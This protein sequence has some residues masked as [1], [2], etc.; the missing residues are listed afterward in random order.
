MDAINMIKQRRSI[1]KYKDEVITKELLDEIVEIARFSPSWANFQVA[2]Y[3]FISDPSDIA[4]ISEDGVNGFAYN[5]KTLS[6]TKNLLVLSFVQAKSG[7]LNPNSDDYST[8]IKNSW[9]IFDAGI[10]TQTFCLAAHAKGVGTCIFGVFDPVVVA[11]IVGLPEDETVAA[12]I[13]LG[14]PDEVVNETTRKEVS[15]I[16]RHK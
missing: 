6:N 15:E 16:T 8:S 10:A 11:Q 12:V 1:R 3:N 13:T 2:R 5:K 9:E 4:R 7:K 14:F